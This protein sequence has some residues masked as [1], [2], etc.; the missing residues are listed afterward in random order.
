MGRKP[1]DGSGQDGTT[2]LGGGGGAELEQGRSELFMPIIEPG[3]QNLGCDSI[4]G[5]S[6]GWSPLT[7]SL[8]PRMGFSTFPNFPL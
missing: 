7:G 4:T 8:G 6:R 3:F 5:P 1:R 2:A